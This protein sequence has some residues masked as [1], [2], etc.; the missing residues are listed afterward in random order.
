VTAVEIRSGY[1][2]GRGSVK[3]ESR[4]TSV[5]I[6]A[7]TVTFLQRILNPVKFIRVVRM[8]IVSASG[9]KLLGLESDHSPLSGVIFIHFYGL[10]LGR[11][12]AYL[13]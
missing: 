1:F 2:M 13:S 10:V 3:S 11:A 5:R 8:D 12:Q 4:G 6:A 9:L 7:R